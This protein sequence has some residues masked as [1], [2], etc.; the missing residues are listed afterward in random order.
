MIKQALASK[1]LQTILLIGFFLYVT[2]IAFLLL[3]HRDCMSV[4]LLG[5][6][7][8]LEAL[9]R[10]ENPYVTTRFLNPTTNNE[11]AD[12]IDARCQ[13]GNGFKIFSYQ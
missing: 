11:L 4:D 8:V 13:L 1:K 12:P 9:H 3:V 10:G 2:R 7:E 6:K 5:W